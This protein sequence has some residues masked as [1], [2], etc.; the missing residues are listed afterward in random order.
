MTILALEFSSSLRT[1]TVVREG[2]VCGSAAE[3]GT[4]H[5]RPI[6]LIREALARAECDRGDVERIAIGLGPGSFTG[7]R[8]AIAIAEG[9]QLAAQVAVVGLSSMEALAELARR[10]GLLGRVNLVVDAQRGEFHVV[11]HA[12][13]A[14]GITL[15]EALR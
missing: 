12:I 4:T 3:E 1:A 7:V 15:L 5:S 6:A 14:A 11:R 10:E 2:R 8:T 9:W 13:S